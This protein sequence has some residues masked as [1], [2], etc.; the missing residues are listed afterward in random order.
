M[1]YKKI[2]TFVMVFAFTSVM[3]DSTITVNGVDYTCTTSCDITTMPG[4]GV[5][6]QDCCGGTV[7]TATVIVEAK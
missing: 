2:V 4:G 1:S 5:V 6:I 7:T 3:A